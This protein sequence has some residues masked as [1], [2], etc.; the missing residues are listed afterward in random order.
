MRHHLLIYKKIRAGRIL[1]EG[2]IMKKIIEGSKYD[3]STAKLMGSDSFSNNRDFS[4]WSEALYRTK[5]GKYFLHGEGGP[6]TKYSVSTGQNQW[7]GGERIIPMDRSSAMAWAEE[8]LDGDDYEK[9]F[10]AVEDGTEQI[11]ITVSTWLKSKLWAIAE[12]RRVTVNVLI[13]EILSDS[14]R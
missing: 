4:H 13:I 2:D 7:S 8:H 14:I 9:I 1:V 5:S 6:M 10:G 11:N 12:E 3:T